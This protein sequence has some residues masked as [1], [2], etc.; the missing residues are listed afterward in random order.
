MRKDTSI[1]LRPALCSACGQ[2]MEAKGQDK[3][4]YCDLCNKGYELYQY[5]LTPVDVMFKM[6]NG[7]DVTGEG[8]NPFWVFDTELTVYN[9]KASS[10]AGS[11]LSGFGKLLSGSNTNNMDSFTSGIAFYVPA[12]YV[13]SIAAFNMGTKLTFEQPL[14][15]EDNPGPFKEIYYNSKD[16]EKIADFIFLSSEIEKPDMVKSM[17]YSLNLSNP[18]LI[19]IRF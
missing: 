15:A 18:R 19:V 1:K 17:D 9:R 3:F 6:Y 7:K 11:L 16:A 2:Q 8:R 10:T 14:M 13:G 5:K 4:F 12:Y